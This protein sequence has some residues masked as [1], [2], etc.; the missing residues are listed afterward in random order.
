MI[1]CQVIIGEVKSFELS[2][3]HLMNHCCKFRISMNT[4]T[5]VENCQ[6]TMIT[7]CN[8][9]MIPNKRKFNIVKEIS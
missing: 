9:I 8:D 4:N 2:M 5:A 3:F 1:L 7:N 6:K